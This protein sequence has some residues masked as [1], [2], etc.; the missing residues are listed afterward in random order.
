M[1]SVTEMLVRNSVSPALS[2]TDVS[3]AEIE[4]KIRLTETWVR[5][6]YLEGGSITGDAVDAVVL[7]VL[8]SLLSRSDLAQKYGTLVSERFG[9]YQYELA[10]PM[11]RGTEFQSDPN[12]V[13]RTWQQM[14]I[15]ILSDI[16]A[17]KKFKVR[18]ANE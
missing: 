3:Q 5:R 14:A 7:M 4:T 16:S 9:D 13:L 12:A 10:G 8:A 2:Y 18:L 1:G 6:R 11:S 15:E 17:S